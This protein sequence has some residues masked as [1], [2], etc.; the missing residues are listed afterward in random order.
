MNRVGSLLSPFFT[1]ERVR[2]YQ[3][4]MT[5]DTAAFA[6]Y[7]GW[8]LEKGIYVAPSQ[9]EAM[10]VSAAHSAEMIDMTCDMVK[11]YGKS[12]MIL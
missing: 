5:S 8:M 9:F 7:F 2:D 3:S 12:G 10:F 11:E 6:R 1:R 4:V